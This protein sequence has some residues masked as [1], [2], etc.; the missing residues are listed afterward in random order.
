MQKTE[1]QYQ[2]NFG[3][4][5][6]PQGSVSKRTFFAT[7]FSPPCEAAARMNTA[8]HDTDH[9]AA[10]AVVDDE[11]VVA[12]HTCN[13][14]VVDT[15]VVDGVEVSTWVFLEAEGDFHSNP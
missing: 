10:G 2:T 11:A 7:Q 5:N 8:L 12:C 3:L 4:Q 15:V 1:K 14:E 13:A 6:S 9:T